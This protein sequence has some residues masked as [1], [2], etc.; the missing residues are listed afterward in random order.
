MKKIFENKFFIIL[1]LFLIFGAVT[2]IATNIGDSGYSGIQVDN[3]FSGSGKQGITQSI[4]FNDSEGNNHLFEFEDGLLVNH[5]FIIPP[6]PEFPLE[7]LI[8]YYK[9]EDHGGVLKDELDEYNGTEV[10]ITHNETA[11]KIG[12]GIISDSSTEL[13]NVSS[14]KYNWNANNWSFAGWAN[15]NATNFIGG[16]FT[17]RPGDY[18]VGYVTLGVINDIV[19]VEVNAITVMQQENPVGDNVW[20]H[21]VLVHDQAASNLSLYMNGFLV[22][23][24]TS[25]GNLGDSLNGNN[26]VEF[27]NWG[28]TSSQTWRGFLDE[29]GIWNRVLNET[30]IQT[31]YNNGEGLT[32]PN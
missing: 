24:T 15:A 19:K 4:S 25:F 30:E 23:S 18:G 17:N 10:N 14:L 6:E 13:I 12:N 28:A 21:Y 9:M 8:A 26:L 27:G 3:Y 1:S 7:G 5:S 22:N 32:Y 29:F 20:R 16:L 11:G 31:I 2:V